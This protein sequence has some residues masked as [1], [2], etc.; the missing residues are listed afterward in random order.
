MAVSTSKIL[1]LFGLISV[2][3]FYAIPKKNNF[4]LS[5][6]SWSNWWPL[7]RLGL[8][9]LFMMSEWWASEIIIFLSGRLPNPEA[10]V[11][12]MSIY[13]NTNAMCFMLPVGFQIAANIRV[14][15]EIGA[16]N[17]QIA[18]KSAWV[19]TLLG[20]VVSVLCGVILFMEREKWGYIFTRSDE[21]VDLLSDLLIVLAL[22]VVADGLQ[23][24]LTGVIRGLGK[25]Q[26]GGPVV[27]FSY[28]AVGIPLSCYLCFYKNFGSIG[29]CIGTAVGTFVHSILYVII[30]FFISWETE[31]TIASTKASDAEVP[32]NVPRFSFYS[33]L[34]NREE[35]I[36]MVSF[37]NPP[38][39][40]G[41]ETR[42]DMD[43]SNHAADSDENL[44]IFRW[45]KVS[46]EEKGTIYILYNAYYYY[47]IFL[48]RMTLIDYIRVFRC[49]K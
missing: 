13:Q 29:L 42:S 30:V 49:I 26:L 37:Q 27:V 33:I 19:A 47:V 8:P 38:C 44:N 36:E 17:P 9:N 39:V 14:G 6:A 35:D 31:A 3:I 7:L 40:V 28:Y 2:L 24:V 11:A 43:I 34:N 41:F 48:V 45:K 18:K 23:A 25:Q 10:C 12:A 1:E 22:Y 16:N 32:S 21:V 15:N 20:L 46:L 4:A 5:W